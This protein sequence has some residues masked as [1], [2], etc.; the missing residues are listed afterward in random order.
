MTREHKTLITLQCFSVLYDIK[1]VKK[2]VQ[3][4]P[5]QTDSEEISSN[6][7]IKEWSSLQK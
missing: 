4:P 2:K 6:D 5:P 7:E 3:A 1:R